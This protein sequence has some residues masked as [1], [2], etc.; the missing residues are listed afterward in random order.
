MNDLARAQRHTP[1]P[2]AE[3]TKV[4]DLH[5]VA[6]S[7]VLE[8]GWTDDDVENEVTIALRD[9]DRPV[10]GNRPRRMREVQP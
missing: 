1:L 2:Q 5:Q 4:D 6:K 3:Q 9:H 10:A 7:L 8:Y